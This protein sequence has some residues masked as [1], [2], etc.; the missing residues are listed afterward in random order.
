MIAEVKALPGG[1]IR[2]VPTR[3]RALADDVESG[4][5]GDAHALAWVIDC[6]NGTIKLGLLGAAAESAPTA[7]LLFGMAMHKLQE[8]GMGR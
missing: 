4:R 7:H 1:D 6:G 5:F 3:L 8:G 2:D